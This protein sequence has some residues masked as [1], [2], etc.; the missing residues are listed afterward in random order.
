MQILIRRFLNWFYGA[1]V[2]VY[3][4]RPA[5]SDGLETNNVKDDGALYDDVVQEGDEMA[6]I[7]GPQPISAQAHVQRSPSST[8]SSAPLKDF[9][10]S[11]QDDDEGEETLADILTRPF[12]VK[13][14][15]KYAL[16]IKL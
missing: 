6:L 15:E 5:L 2:D 10:H 8:P 14:Q 4:F 13:Y 12:G 7:G 1:D 16:T 9:S 11:Y 3:I